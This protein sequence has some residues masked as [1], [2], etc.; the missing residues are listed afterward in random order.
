[1]KGGKKGEPLS[2]LDRGGKSQAGVF[3]AVKLRH[4]RDVN[5]ST[6]RGR[7]F[8]SVERIRIQRRRI[9]LEK[10]HNAGT[11]ARC[12]PVYGAQDASAAN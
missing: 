7:N 1:V 2:S 9:I 8:T 12:S 3:P 6:M 11:M 10:D 5:S 4:I